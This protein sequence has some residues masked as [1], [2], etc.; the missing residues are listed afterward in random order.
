MKKSLEPTCT[1]GTTSKADGAVKSPTD[2]KEIKRFS[3]KL[4]EY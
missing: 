2:Y 1:A 3:G 4:K